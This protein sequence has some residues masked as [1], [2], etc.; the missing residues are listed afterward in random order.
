LE[1]FED[2]FVSAKNVK[3]YFS[4]YPE[5]LMKIG[6]MTFWWS[7]DNYGQ[8]LQCYALQ[9]Y[10]RDAGHDAYLIRY[11][12]R[13]DYVKTPVWK[14]LLKAFN[15]IT[16]INFFHYRIKKQIIYGKIEKLNALRRFD[17]FKNK[18]IRQSKNIYH[19]YRELVVDPP[20]A[21]V[22]IAGSDQV[23]N[24][25]MLSFKNNGNQTGAFFLNFGNTE[26]KR[27]A[28]AVS[29]GKERLAGNYIKEITPLLKKFNYVSVREKSGLDICRQCGVTGA[30]WVPDPTMLLGAADYRALAHEPAIKIEKPYC[31]VYMLSNECNFSI[32][33]VYDW[34]EKRNLNVV[35][36]TG[37]LRHDK[38]KK[39]YADIGEWLYLIDKAEY[40]ITNSYH[41]SIFSLLFQ[42]QFG[43]I[44][45]TGKLVGMNSRFNALF[46]LF[47][48][49]E[50]FIDTAFNVLDETINWDAIDDRFRTI[51]DSCGLLAVLQ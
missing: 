12:P 21:D 44:P 2:V 35:Y 47:L 8:I 34:V 50:R 15:P 5:C 30:E 23:W 18:Y 45:L 28:Y 9:K 49:N 13:N 17:N 39:I 6:I 38:H 27:I 19:S 43:L 37:N 41:C 10:L 31:L 33:A 29:F 25:D 16:L 11:D 20:E 48:I 46:E 42:K 26:T 22:Y 4:I 32:E 36:I 51:Q 24:P 3:K 1:I 14:R 7:E 40:V